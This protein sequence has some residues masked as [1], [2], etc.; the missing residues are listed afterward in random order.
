MAITR[1]CKSTARLAGRAM[2]CFAAGVMPRKRSSAKAH[3]QSRKAIATDEFEFAIKT[4]TGQAIKTVR[5]AF[6]YID[7]LPEKTRQRLEWQLA[8]KELHRAV[9]MDQAGYSSLGWQ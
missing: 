3:S 2:I 4:K 1:D 8:I 9:T 6:D 7:A 5:E